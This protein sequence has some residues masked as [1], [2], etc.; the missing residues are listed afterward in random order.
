M[1]SALIDSENVAGAETVDLAVDIVELSEED[2]AMVD[3]VVKDDD[4]LF[5]LM[6]IL[7]L[8]FKGPRR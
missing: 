2:V 6:L 5:L 8:S 7:L 1:Y 3:T 4:K